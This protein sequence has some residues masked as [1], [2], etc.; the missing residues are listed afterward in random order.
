M[1]ERL[2]SPVV[3]KD[4]SVT[5]NLK[6]EYAKTVEVSG[7]FVFGPERH[8]LDARTPMKKGPGSVW[9]LTSL[10]MLP[11]T[12][13]YMYVVD[14]LRTLDPLNP[15]IRR[16]AEPFRPLGL[17]MNIVRIE[18][19]EPMPWDVFSDIPHGR[20]VIEKF[21]SETLRQ[22]KGC[23][24][25]LPPDYKPAQ[26]YPVLYLLH[27]G[28][29]D[30]LSWI[31]DEA[32]D[33]IMDYL[34]Y[35]GKTREMIVAMPDGQ[36]GAFGALIGA[37][38][39]ERRRL[40]ELHEDYFFK[41]VMPFVESR[42]RVS[43]YTRTI[44]GLSMG[45]MQTSAIVTAHPEIFAA[46]GI[47]SSG[48]SDQAR[49]RIPSIKDRLNGLK[50]LYVS[51]GNWDTLVQ[52]RNRALCTQLDENGIRYVYMSADAGHVAAFWQRSLVDYVSHLSQIL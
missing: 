12:Y 39:A 47:F 11:G 6:N 13:G 42:Y 44:A 51:C 37:P 19:D 7:D 34:I 21:Y 35:K 26:E 48:A 40:A 23:T 33:N 32:T 5:F 22:V 25:Y 43:R 41:E 30:Y 28:G 45:G 29:N 15:L 50:L 46:A 9:T 52:E 17:R 8:V 16:V 24:F 18:A 20:V 49:E 38:P 3:N 27:G 14:G 31:F 4:R 1:N 36:V 2:A 10:P